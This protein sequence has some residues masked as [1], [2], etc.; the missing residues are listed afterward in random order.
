MPIK[1]LEQF[2]RPPVAGYAKLGGKESK[3][4]TSKSGNKWRAPIK[5][6]EFRMV[7][8]QRDETDNYVLDA[9]LQWK[10][11]AWNATEDE[12]AAFEAASTPKEKADTVR[13]VLVREIPIRLPSDDIDECLETDYVHYRGTVLHRKCDGESCRVW[14]VRKTDQGYRRVTNRVKEVV[15]VCPKYSDTGI[16]DP[17]GGKGEICSPSARLSFFVAIDDQGNDVR[18]IAATLGACYQFRTKGWNSIRKLHGSLVGIKAMV[19]KLTGVP[20]VLVAS[21]VTTKDAKGHT[22]RFLAAHVEC[23]VDLV[24][25]IT[26]ARSL[27][28]SRRRLALIGDTHIPPEPEA[29]QIRRHEENAAEYHPDQTN[30]EEHREYEMEQNEA[31][32]YEAVDDGDD[33]EAPLFPDDD[34]P[35]HEAGGQPAQSEEWEDPDNPPTEH[36]RRV[37]RAYYDEYKRLGGDL[38]W[39]QMCASAE[40]E[41]IKL[42]FAEDDALESLAT[43]LHTWLVNHKGADDAAGPEDFPGSDY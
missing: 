24:E 15:C 38:S 33:P 30:P 39:D 10:L 1:A 37:V 34:A 32:E 20:L 11:K 16:V 12:R 42:A 31:G 26:G 3:E 23:R 6:P 21:E 17:H 19:G 41:P 29:E 14:D 4:R 25:V 40:V 7:K 2:K 35:V 36:K 5:F 43:W 27:H 13:H 8:M 28:E 9:A 18:K 22:R